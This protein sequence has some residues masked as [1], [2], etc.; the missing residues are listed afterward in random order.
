MFY[1]A[2]PHDKIALV[3]GNQNYFKKEYDKLSYTH[4]DAYDI[5]SALSR[6]GFKVTNSRT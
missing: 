5:A 6:L 1:V 2:A 4:N 3:I